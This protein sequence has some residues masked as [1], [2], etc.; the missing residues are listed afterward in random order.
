MRKGI[1]RSDHDDVVNDIYEALCE[2]V[3][4]LAYKSKEAVIRREIEKVLR[5]YPTHDEDN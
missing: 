4:E 2:V 1:H 5:R 3:P